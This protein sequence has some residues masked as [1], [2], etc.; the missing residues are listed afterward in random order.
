M[1]IAM[2]QP[3]FLPYTGFFYKI[4]QSNTFDFAVHDQFVKDGYQRRVKFNDR[5]V[6]V[7]IIDR[8]KLPQ[9]IA[10]NQVMVDVMKTGENI[11][12]GMDIEYR[13]EPHYKKIRDEIELFFSQAPQAVMDLASFNIALTAF[14]LRLLG[15]LE[16]TNLTISPKPTQPKSFGIIEIMKNYFPDHDTYLSGTGGKAYTGTEFEDNGL[17]IEYSNHNAIHSDSIIGTL[18]RYDDPLSIILKENIV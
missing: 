1:K 10:I 18:V 14:M 12:K 17:K 15:V 13:N 4:L 2:H 6:N 7:A 5:W 8:K 3:D 11:L 16:K 9:K